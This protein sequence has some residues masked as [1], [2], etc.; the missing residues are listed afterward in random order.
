M[1]MTGDLER[2]RDERDRW[3]RLFNRL[4][5]AV[6]HHKKASGDF[7]Q[8]HDEA[9]YKARA[10]ILKDAGARMTRDPET[11]RTKVY[12]EHGNLIGEQG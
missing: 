7:P 3:I 2:M 11:G 10:Q 9:L 12:G 6:S 4:E 1:A 5:G 8:A